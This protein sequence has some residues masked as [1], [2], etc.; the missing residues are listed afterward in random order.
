[1]INFLRRLMRPAAAAPH[2]PYRP[3]AQELA[4]MSFGQR[5]IQS[6]SSTRIDW[7]HYSAEDVRERLAAFDAEAY[8]AEHADDEI[9][10]AAVAY[11]RGD[12]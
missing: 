11:A 10:M 5:A 12:E 3:T 4:S 9:L 6:L 8:L 2:V 1:M 7:N